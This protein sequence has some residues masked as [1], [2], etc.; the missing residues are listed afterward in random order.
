MPVN[1]CASKDT[2][3][4]GSV[5]TSVLFALF[6]VEM[7]SKSAVEDNDFVMP[8]EDTAAEVGWGTQ[9]EKA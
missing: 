2:K 5:Y 8:R 7:S 9:E 4:A 1:V 3:P 6:L